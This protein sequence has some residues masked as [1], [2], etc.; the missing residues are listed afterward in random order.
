MPPL[1]TGPERSARRRDC[2][3]KLLDPITWQEGEEIVP[4]PISLKKINYEGE[5]F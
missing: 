2:P 5:C 1:A 4:S 3:P